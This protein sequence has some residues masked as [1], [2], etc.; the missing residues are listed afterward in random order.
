MSMPLTDAVGIHAPSRSMFR[1][2]HVTARRRGPAANVVMAGASVPA[3]VDRRA[4]SGG[5]SGS[6]PAARAGSGSRP[7]RRRPRAGAGGS[8]CGIASISVRVY[9]CFGRDSTSSAGPG[10]DDPPE[11][12][13]GDAVG[14]V[15][16]DRQ[17]VGDEARAPR[18]ARA[19]GRRSGSGSGPARARRAPTPARRPRSGRARAPAPP[20]SPRAGAGR[21][22]ARAAGASRVP[23]REP[24]ALEQLAD[25][26]VSVRGA[27]RR[28][29]RRAARA[30][31]GRP[32]SAGRASCRGPG[33]S[34]ARGGGSSRAARPAGPTSV[35]SNT[36]RARGRPHQAEQA[37]AE[38]RL[39]RA[40][41][42]D[43]GQHLA[44]ATSR[45]TSS[46][47]RSVA[48]A[49]RRR[50]PPTR[51]SRVTPR[52]SSRAGATALTR[53]APPRRAS[54]AVA[55]PRLAGR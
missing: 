46:T 13:D 6:P 40:R 43:H 18:R 1:G 3:D 38:R 19:A 36:H 20:R 51:K 34:A 2:G 23:L 41:L 52:A 31:C 10:L 8:G 21:P 50:P 29:T 12:H 55:W 35:P 27:C 30:R 32:S 49:R 44:G 53:P 33:R 37:A 26:A 25:P 48:D 9:G 24:D 4:G 47:A 14:D 42:A 45:S 17:V 5:G 16:D 39:A 54:S 7:A 11:V 28:R 22:R 15:L